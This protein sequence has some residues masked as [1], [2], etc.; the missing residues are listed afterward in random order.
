[1][2]DWIRSGHGL[3]F[4]YNIFLVIL[5]ISVVDC[6]AEIRPRDLQN[7]KRNTITP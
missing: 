5:Q 1:M 4:H 7:K 6:R 3:C 2:T